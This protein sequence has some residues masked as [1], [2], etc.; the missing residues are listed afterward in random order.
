MVFINISYREVVGPK[1]SS[2]LSS[3]DSTG[4]HIHRPRVYVSWQKWEK[5]C[6]L[7]LLRHF[8]NIFGLSWNTSITFY[9]KLSWYLWRWK[10]TWWQWCK[11]FLLY[12]NKNTASTLIYVILLF[13]FFFCRCVARISDSQAFSLEINIDWDCRLPSL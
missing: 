6:W 1:K 4:K 3:T 11:S 7:H 5:Q 13:F 9:L 12:V 2:F 8:N 10:A